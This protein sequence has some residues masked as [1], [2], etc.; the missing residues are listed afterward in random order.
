MPLTPSQTIGP[1]FHFALAPADSPAADAQISGAVYDGG[2]APVSD[3]LLEF[4]S[5]AGIARAETNANG[6]FSAAVARKGSAFIPI[7]LF[8]RGLLRQ[9]STRVYFDA[10]ALAADPALGALPAAR[11]QTMVATGRGEGRWSLD[12]RLQGADETV[13]LEY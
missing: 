8:A 1:F 13:F 5:A 3:A 11:R 6:H 9:L 12:I 7:V 4:W 2:G 10:A